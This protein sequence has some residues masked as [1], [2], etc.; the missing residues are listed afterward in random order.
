MGVFAILQQNGVG[1]I[2]MNADD[3]ISVDVSLPESKEG[4]W[5]K[6]VIALTDTGDVFKLSCM[7]SHWQRTKAF[8]D[9]GAGKVTHWMPLNYPDD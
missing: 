9:S 5:S 3:W 6:E 2:T 7:G 1:S 4:M 8:T